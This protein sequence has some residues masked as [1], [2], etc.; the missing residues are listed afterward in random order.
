[1]KINFSIII[2]CVINLVSGCSATGTNETS[3]AFDTE[4]GS[5]FSIRNVQSGFM[6]P[7]VLD[8]Q[9]Q[10]LR[11]WEVVPQVTPVEILAQSPSGWVQFKDPGSTNCLVAQSGR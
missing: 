9:G 6:I 3:N 4:N 8:Q 1:M 2:I 5:L 7:N 10:E 11:G